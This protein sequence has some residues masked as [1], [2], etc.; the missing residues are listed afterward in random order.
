MNCLLWAEEVEMS[1]NVEIIGLPLQS[2]LVMGE[3][4]R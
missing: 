2:I 1:K 4:I 3:A